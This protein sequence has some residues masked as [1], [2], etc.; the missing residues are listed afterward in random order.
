MD[1]PLRDSLKIDDIIASFDV[2]IFPHGVVRASGVDDNGD[3]LIAIV[4]ILLS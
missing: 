4:L 1:C 3:K 2:V